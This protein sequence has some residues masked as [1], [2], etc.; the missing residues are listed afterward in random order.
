M[1]WCILFFDGHVCYWFNRHQLYNKCHCPTSRDYSS[2][3]WTYY[4][5]PAQTYSFN[6]MTCTFYRVLYVG[7]RILWIFLWFHRQQL[8]RLFPLEPPFVSPQ[9][10]LP[11]NITFSSWSTFQSFLL[12]Y[13]FLRSIHRLLTI[14]FHNTISYLCHYW[15]LI[16]FWYYFSSILEDIFFQPSSV[17]SVI[18]KTSNLYERSTL[19]VVHNFWGSIMCFILISFILPHI[20]WNLSP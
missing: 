4:Y 17:T 6:V 3:N 15:S 19:T 10:C 20:L 11:F 1:F 13:N 9:L 12:G 5:V 8:K 7:Q 18:V 16:P 2:L 14:Y